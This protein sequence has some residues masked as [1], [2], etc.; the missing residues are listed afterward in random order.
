MSG[1]LHAYGM[2]A[3]AGRHTT[4]L[5]L[6]G[7]DTPRPM[8]ALCGDF[9]GGIGRAMPHVCRAPRARPMPAHAR[10]PEPARPYVAAPLCPPAL[11]PACPMRLAL[12]SSARGQIG[13]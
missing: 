4:A 11:V 10:E 13:V 3:N 7:N 12:C 1:F 9:C 2:G 5:H 8:I 6:G